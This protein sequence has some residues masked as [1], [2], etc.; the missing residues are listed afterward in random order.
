M[1]KDDNFLKPEHKQLIKLVLS[2]KFPLY[3]T[4]HQ[5][6]PDKR[7]YLSHAFLLHDKDKN[8]STINSNLYEKVLDILIT[9]CNKN[10]ITFN[11][12]L[13]VNLNITFPLATKKGKF[14]KDHKFDHKQLIV[15]INNSDGD[16]VLKK[17]GRIK[18]K[19]Y[20]GVC[21]DNQMH[22]AETPSKD[23]RAVLIYT[24]K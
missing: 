19:R 17:E 6:F 12:C 7:P 5:V 3:W 16:T 10:N 13:R 8:I 14:H 9:F 11:E 21:F 15:Y 2:N 22:Y 24:F 1:I 18:N 23:R 20:R 4:E